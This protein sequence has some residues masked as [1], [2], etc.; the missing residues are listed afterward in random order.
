[1]NGPLLE[2][3]E[4]TSRIPILEIFW[5]GFKVSVS[6]IASSSEGEGKVRAT[7]THHGNVATDQLPLPPNSTPL[8][9]TPVSSASLTEL[10]DVD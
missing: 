7:L 9:Q 4:M 8:Y 5:E 1:M 6:V 10:A 3:T 2:S